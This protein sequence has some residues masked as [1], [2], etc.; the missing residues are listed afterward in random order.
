[1]NRLVLSVAAGAT[2][3]IAGCAD[4]MKET[5]PPAA[6]ATGPSALAGFAPGEYKTN[7]PSGCA[8]LTISGG[9]PVLYSW[10]QE[11]DGSLDFTSRPP[12]LRAEGDRVYVGRRDTSHYGDIRPAGAGFSATQEFRGRK[13]EV[14]FSPD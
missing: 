4:D 3:A 11:C 2:L 13:F 1:M 6:A 8:Y 14:Q 7:Q 12:K 9:E 10:D 5:P